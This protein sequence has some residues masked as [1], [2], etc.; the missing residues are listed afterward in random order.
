SYFSTSDLLFHFSTSLLFH[1]ARARRQP[2]SCVTMCWLSR[3]SQGRSSM[4][5]AFVFGFRRTVRGAVTNGCVS[6]SGSSIV[7]CHV[8]VLPLRVYFSTTCMLLLWNQ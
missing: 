2:R 7:A 4:S 5:V 8:S 1:F 6:T 3:S